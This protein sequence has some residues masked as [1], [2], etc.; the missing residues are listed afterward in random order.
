MMGHILGDRKV[1]THIKI[2][3][4]IEN[5]FGISEKIEDEQVFTTSIRPE[6]ELFSRDWINN[7]VTS[8]DSF[9][10]KYQEYDSKITFELKRAVVKKK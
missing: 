7:L 1:R 2:T 3:Y 5:E 8:K 9:G 10:H 4:L 6:N